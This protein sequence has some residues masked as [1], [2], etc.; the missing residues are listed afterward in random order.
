MTVYANEK[1]IEVMNYAAVLTVESLQRRLDEKRVD[2]DGKGD[3]TGRG[4]SD[5]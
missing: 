4:P 1:Y 2:W 5:G 3:G